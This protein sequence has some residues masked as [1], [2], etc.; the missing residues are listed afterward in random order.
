VQNMCPT[1][2]IAGISVIIRSLDR[3]INDGGCCGDFREDLRPSPPRWI[4]AK[5]DP[6]LCYLHVAGRC[7]A[8]RIVKFVSRQRRVSNPAC[9]A[10]ERSSRSSR[11]RNVQS[12]FLIRFARRFARASAIVVPPMKRCLS[13]PDVPYDCRSAARSEKRTLARRSVPSFFRRRES[14]ANSEEPCRRD[15]MAI[16]APSHPEDSVISKARC[17]GERVSTRGRLACSRLRSGAQRGER[18]WTRTRGN[19]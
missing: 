17:V 8:T 19:A 14:C 5:F 18:G 12:E 9:I 15:T 11:D 3:V 1:A 10:R 16:S 7:D 6:I 2:S 13:H 4:Y